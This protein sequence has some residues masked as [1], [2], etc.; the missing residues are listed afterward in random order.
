MARVKYTCVVSDLSGS[1]SGTTFQK[2]SSGSIARSKATQSFF[3]SQLQS[4]SRNDFAKV[5]TYWSKLDLSVQ[6]NWNAYASAHPIYDRWGNVKTLNGFQYYMQSNINLLGLGLEIIPTPP[7]FSPQEIVPNYEIVAYSNSLHLDFYPAIN[8]PDCDLVIYASAP[9]TSSSLLNRKNIWWIGNFSSP[10]AGIFDIKTMYEQC[11]NVTWS[12][13]FNSATCNIVFQVILVNRVTGIASPFK[14]FILSLRNAPEPNWANIGLSLSSFT[15]FSSSGSFN[16]FA[17]CLNGFVVAVGYSSAP[18]SFSS[19]NGLSWSVPSGSIIGTNFLDCLFL[20]NGVVLIGGGESAR[21][22][23]STDYGKSFSEAASFPSQKTVTSFAKCA[24][25]VIF[26]VLNP[27]GQLVKSVDNGL[28]WSLDLTISAGLVPFKLCYLESGIIVAGMGGTSGFY[29]SVDNGASWLHVSLPSPIAQVRAIAYCGN[30]IIVAGSYSSNGVWR[31]V[32]YGLT[33]S[34]I[35]PL[36]GSGAYLSILY[37]GNGVLLLGAGA[38]INLF[39]SLD[40]GL[41]WS[42]LGPPFASSGVY[43]LLFAKSNV[44]LVG[45]FSNGVMARA[46]Y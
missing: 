13:F 2:N 29:R 19:D 5:S 32:D 20:G 44:L 10:N 7:I 45:G 17:D 40:Y 28:S 41:T 30:G 4:A 6:Q 24:N 9:T 43:S 21:I 39:K 35:G 11:F 1:V 15:P 26:A 33:W 31:S 14:G 36:T 3:P 46:K 27:S 34:Y 23:R 18:V 12:S 16:A 37:C 42:A 25:G 38:Y 8:Y 22:Y